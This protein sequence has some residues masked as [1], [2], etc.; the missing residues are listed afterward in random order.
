METTPLGRTGIEVSRICIGCWQAAGWATSDDERFV[1]TVRHALDLGLTFLD[2]AVGYGSGHSEELVGKAIAG[3][4]DQV[5]IA[6]KFSHPSSRPADVRKACEDACQRLGTDHLDLFQQHWPPKDIPLAETI[7][8]L[9]ELKQEGKI[10]AIGVSNWM[11]PEWGELDDPSR[12][13][14]LQPN[15]SLLWRSIEPNVLPLCRQHNIGIITYSSICQGIL[16]GKFENLDD[17]PQDSRSHNRR[18][19]PEE[20]PQVLE[21]L[22]VLR[23]VADKYE[24]TLAQTAIRWLLDQPGVTAAIVGASRPEQVDRNIGALGWSL[25]ADDW[26]RLADVSRPLSEGLQPHDTLWHWHPRTN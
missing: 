24:K 23:D 12:V 5:V 20:F 13:D 14:C 11:E 1:E 26:Q 16:A 7:G 25:D 22:A 2:T 4:R 18:L 3:R 17:I 8:A 10:R 15:Y 9:E 6:T 21:V 19:T